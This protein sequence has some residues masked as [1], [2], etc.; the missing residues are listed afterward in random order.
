MSGTVTGVTIQSN[1]PLLFRNNLNT[2]AKMMV[3]SLWDLRIST[4]IFQPLRYAESMTLIF[5]PI[6]SLNNYNHKDFRSLRF[7]FNMKASTTLLYVRKIED[8]FTASVT[9]TP[10]QGSYS[11]KMPLLTG[12]RR[13]KKNLDLYVTLKVWEQQT[14]TQLSIVKDWLLE[15]TSSMLKL[16]GVQN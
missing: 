9:H 8:A 2:L 10:T 11:V 6:A 1:G 16:T 4:N 7:L 12:L 3:F 15:N 13:Q 14:A 5:T